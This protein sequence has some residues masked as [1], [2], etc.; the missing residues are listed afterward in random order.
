MYCGACGTR[1]PFNAKYCHECGTRLD[2]AH[3]ARPIPPEEFELPPPE[4]VEQKVRALL[5][6]AFRAYEQGNLEEAIAQCREAVKLQPANA[7]A[8]SLLGLLY[9]RRGEREAAIR[10]YETALHLNPDSEADRIS[11]ARLRGEPL[12]LPRWRVPFPDW[13]PAMAGMAVG[14]LAFLVGSWFLFLWS[15]KEG[16]PQPQDWLQKGWAYYR[17]GQYQAAAEAFQEVLKRNPQDVQALQGWQASQQALARQ[18]LYAARPSPPPEG[19]PTLSAAIAP[20]PPASPSSAPSVASSRPRATPSPSPRPSA[21]REEPRAVAQPS[22]TLPPLAPEALESAGPSTPSSEAEQSPPLE[23][24]EGPP[25]SG[26]PKGYIRIEVRPGP[27][28]RPSS[29]TP[30]A[31]SETRPQPLAP[32]ERDLLAEARAIERRANQLAQQGR[33]D[34]ALLEYRRVLTTAPNYPQAGRIWQQI[35]LCQQRLRNEGEALEAYRQAEKHLQAALAS[36][37]SDPA[38]ESALRAVRAARELLERKEESP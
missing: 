36:T 9:E 11:L 16:Q 29:P 1:N 17:Q 20:L 37:P 30:P 13:V 3:G 2:E 38:T 7:A 33:Y 32:Q 34:L 21:P 19:P 31:P 4:E 26:P 18:R 12:P 5:E 35:G 23:T 6:A 15:G 24:A 8:H 25:P 28:G 10:E 22:I 27:G 14:V